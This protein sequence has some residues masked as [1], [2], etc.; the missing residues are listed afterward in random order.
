MF[1]YVVLYFWLFY[2]ATPNIVGEKLIKVFQ[3]MPS[4]VTIVLFI[5]ASFGLETNVIT[6]SGKISFNLPVFIT[7]LSF[8]A[9]LSEGIIPN[10]KL[11][12]THY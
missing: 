6:L 5:S 11:S 9:S 12:V 3:D 1:Q 7:A 10:V 8:E 2:C 4:S